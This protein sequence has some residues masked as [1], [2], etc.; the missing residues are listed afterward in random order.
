M[1]IYFQS[2]TVFIPDYHAGIDQQ[3]EYSN[4]NW[5]VTNVIYN[6]EGATARV[7][8]KIWQTNAGIPF[9]RSFDFDC[10]TEWSIQDVINALLGLELFNGSVVI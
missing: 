10:T 5:Q 3:I 8:V 4:F 7:F 1:N 6:W 2:N 9:T